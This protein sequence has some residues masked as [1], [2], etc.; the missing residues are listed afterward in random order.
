MVVV[1]GINRLDEDAVIGSVSITAEE[2]YEVLDR[3]FWRRCPADSGS[4]RRTR[5]VFTVLYHLRDSSG[6]AADRD[7][8]DEPVFSG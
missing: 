6:E 3:R 7:A 2:I 5:N 8:V 4:A 1:D